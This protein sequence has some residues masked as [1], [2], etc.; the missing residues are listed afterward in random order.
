MQWQPMCRGT[1]RFSVSS[2]AVHCGATIES[3]QLGPPSSKSGP[4]PCCTLWGSPITGEGLSCSCS[5]TTATKMPAALTSSSPSFP[6]WPLASLQQT[7]YSTCQTGSCLAERE[8]YFFFPL[9]AFK[10]NRITML[11][12]PLAISIKLRASAC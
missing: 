12:Q 7:H 1:C 10:A 9:T 4:S 2:F 8:R 3:H 5:P 11:L 6:R